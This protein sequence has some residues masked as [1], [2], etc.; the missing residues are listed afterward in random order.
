MFDALVLIAAGVGIGQ[1]VQTNIQD[2]PIGLIRCHL[3]GSSTAPSGRRAR[4]REH[5]PFRRPS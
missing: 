3:M 5:V 2:L 4:A 1:L